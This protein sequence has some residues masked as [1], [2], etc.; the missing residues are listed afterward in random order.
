MNIALM[1]VIVYIIVLYAASWYSTKLSKKD[2]VVGY[3]LAGRKF[4][5]TLLAVML[6]AQAIGGAA[7]VGVAAKAYTVGISAAAYTVAWFVAAIIIGTFFVKKYRDMTVTTF[8]EIFGICFDKRSRI[9]ASV[10]QVIILTTINALMYIAGGAILSSLLPDIFTMT[11]GM[12]TSVIVFVG[13]TLI[14]GLWAAGITNIINLIVIYVG[15]ILGAF[16]SI[17]QVG[18]FSNLIASLPANASGDTSFWFNPLAGLGIAVALGWIV[19]QTTNVVVSQSM[20]QIAFAAKDGK[21]ARKGFIIGSFLMLPIGFLSAL[22]G[23]VAAVKFPG[24]ESGSLALPSVA[25]MLPPAIAGLMLSGLWACDVS[26]SVGL[27]MASGQIFAKDI[28][29]NIF[30][31]ENTDKQ[32]LL[33]SRISILIL[34][35]LGYIL[36]T[37]IKSMLGS[38]MFTLNVT[39][40]MF[41]IITSVFYAPKFCKK[42]SAFWTMIAGILVMIIWKLIPSSHI[43]SN[44]VYLEFPVCLITFFMI[45]IFDKRP[46]NNLK[47]TDISKEGC[48]S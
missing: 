46:I 29:M 16:M 6:A 7:T 34:A 28:V 36:A 40:P 4:G 35:V 18:G 14:G 33:V 20:T 21:V 19:T 8:P 27:L 32:Q 45:Y 15:V 1:I 31:I 44:V 5:P 24:L 39:V 2:G 10:F 42:S 11:S 9:L 26:T 30:K 12:I 25:M 17:N 13:I 48:A 38:L 22:F 37:T 3:L 23:I 47:N 41:I 43:F